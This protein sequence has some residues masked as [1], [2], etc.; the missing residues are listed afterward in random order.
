M[1]RPLIHKTLEEK[2]QAG[3]EKRRR[4]YAKNRDKILR[5][6]RELRVEKHMGPS[7][8]EQAIARALHGSGS[9]KD[10]DSDE[11]ETD[12]SSDIEENDDPLSDL[13]GCLLTLKVIK[14]EMLTLIPEPCAFA[15]GVLLQFVNSITYTDDRAD[16]GD[17]TIV[18]NMIPMVQG[19]L[20]RSIPVQDQILNFCG[21]SPEFHAADT[22]SRYLSTTLAYLEDIE[23]FFLVEGVSELTTDSRFKNTTLIVALLMRQ[24]LTLPLL[25]VPT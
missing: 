16:D 19:L 2:L 12:N 3:R 9:D 7:E 22:V 25:L 11:S 1:P 21:V 23:F 4:H 24:F 8:L 20:N 13:T 15:E 14:D 10:G 6:R 18:T 17:R 5:R